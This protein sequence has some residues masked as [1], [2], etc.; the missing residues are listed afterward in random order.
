MAGLPLSPATLP[1]PHLPVSYTPASSALP[2]VTYSRMRRAAPEKFCAS[3]TK[4]SGRATAPAC[5]RER[6]KR[7]P[8]A[9]KLTSFLGLSFWKCAE[10]SSERPWI[11]ES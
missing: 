2:E 11:L 3:A 9:A 7:L 4:G 5:E 10:R 8:A 6:S 1:L